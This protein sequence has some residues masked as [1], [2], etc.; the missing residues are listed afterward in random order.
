M[1]LLILLFLPLLP[2]ALPVAQAVPTVV[3]TRPANNAVITR[4]P[5]TIALVAT[6]TPSAGASIE[7]VDFYNGAMLIGSVTTPANGSYSFTWTNVPA[8]TYALTAQATD[9]AQQ[10]GVSPVLSIVASQPPQVALSSPAA[11]TVF[12]APADILLTVAASA[13]DTP[14]TPIERVDFYVNWVLMGSDT[15]APYTFLWEQVPAGAYN[16]SAAAI[17]SAGLSNMSAATPI[18]VQAEPGVPTV[19]LTQPTG[20]STYIAPDSITLRASVTPDAGTSI[21]E[22]A[23][24]R[25]NT[26]IGATAS[27][28]CSGTMFR[29]EHTLSRP[30]RPMTPIRPGARFPCPSPSSPRRSSA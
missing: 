17:N 25:G 3:F 20:N 15:E 5:A 6:A 4:L 11:N 30:E 27:I 26:L 10:T 23:F 12:D 9:S 18:T 8:G 21:Q 1:L 19:A 13:T 2:F 29:R 22:V 14:G 24:F 28:R 7:Q 16:L